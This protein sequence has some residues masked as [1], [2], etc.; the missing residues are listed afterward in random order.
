MN[1][2]LAFSAAHLA[3][4]E[5]PLTPA[6]ATELSVRRS[7]GVDNLAI[8]LGWHVTTRDGVE[9]IWHN[10]G[11]GGYSSFIG[12]SPRT[13]TGVVVL[14]NSTVGVDDLALRLVSQLHR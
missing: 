4:D 7:T 10:G 5:A 11:T 1:D 13:G 8:A 6:I 12:Y 9:F 3:A 2:L 14:S